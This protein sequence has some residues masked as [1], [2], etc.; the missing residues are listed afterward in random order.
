MSLCHTVVVE[1]DFES[2]GGVVK[3][4]KTMQSQDSM[5][6]HQKIK[7]AFRKSSTLRNPDADQKEEEPKAK[8]VV[9]IDPN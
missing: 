3:V 2:D 7:N 5:S 1:K 6:I 8:K 9:S 4:A